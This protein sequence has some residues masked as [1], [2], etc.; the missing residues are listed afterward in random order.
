MPVAKL[1]VDERRGHVSGRL[2]PPVE[3]LEAAGAQLRLGPLAQPRAPL[4]DASVVVAVDQVDGLE[5]GH[6]RIVWAATDGDGR[7]S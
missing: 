4:V 2:G 7:R 6:G 5:I 1:S 3:C